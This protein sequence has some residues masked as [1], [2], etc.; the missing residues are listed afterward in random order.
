M[1]SK[2]K[3]NDFVKSKK[4]VGKEQFRRFSSHEEKL[5]SNA[6]LLVKTIKHTA[7]SITVNKESINVTSR[8]LSLPELIGKSRHASDTVRNH[9]LLGISEYIRRFPKDSRLNLYS[10]IQIAS[11]NLLSGAKN[12]RSTSRHLLQSLVINYLGNLSDDNKCFQCICKHLVQGILSSNVDIRNDVY[13]V[14]NSLLQRTPQLLKEYGL[15]ILTGLINDIKNVDA[16]YI[17]CIYGLCDILSVPEEV[18]VLNFALKTL[19]YM[20]Q[21]ADPLDELQC[22]AR[23]CSTT[24][25]LMLIRKRIAGITNP[26]R[27]LWIL[28]DAMIIELESMTPKG[29]ETFKTIKQN[30]TLVVAEIAMEMFKRFPKIQLIMLEHILRVITI[31]NPKG[32]AVGISNIITLALGTQE[33]CEIFTIK[34]SWRR[35]LFSLFTLCKP[36]LH[37][38]EINNLHGILK[39]HVTN[40]EFGGT[41]EPGN[42]ELEINVKCIVREILVLLFNL[43]QGTST[44]LNI[45]IGQM[46]CPWILK[47]ICGITCYSNFRF[48]DDL[49]PYLNVLI[50][51]HICLDELLHLFQF[52]CLDKVI[53]VHGPL[54][55]IADGFTNLNLQQKLALSRA[56]AQLEPSKEIQDRVKGLFI[57]S[58]MDGCMKSTREFGTIYVNMVYNH[59]TGIQYINDKVVFNSSLAKD[60]LVSSMEEMV[61]LS[62]TNPLH[63]DVCAGVFLLFLERAI[64]RLLS[65][66]IATITS[67]ED[68]CNSVSNVVLKFFGK[69]RES[70]FKSLMLDVADACVHWLLQCREY[71]FANAI[72]DTLSASISETAA[73]SEAEKTIH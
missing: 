71:A 56:F 68:A 24:K 30:Y 1:G 23:A 49:N 63:P 8:R 34:R 37:V 6:K 48:I 62:L 4:R 66:K 2:K 18:D 25:L 41:N 22:L 35:L 60:R 7:Q 38:E 21:L 53:D 3:V 13:V 52:R 17:N 20:Q 69:K 65:L 5:I 45:I 16:E 40:T 47:E 72:L 36:F 12:V 27:Y 28:S 31:E 15:R 58:M 10:L 32:H 57:A 64:V 42:F 73:P 44:S 51:S 59:A 26:D 61:E 9:A 55:K 43:I 33:W 11:A 70:Q 67:I 54:Y 19:E 50:D 46:N 14:I 39:G 29:V